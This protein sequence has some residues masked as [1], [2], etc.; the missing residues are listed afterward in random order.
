MPTAKKSVK[1]P[2]SPLSSKQRDYLVNRVH[3]IANEQYTL[4]REHFEKYDRAHPME[5]VERHYSAL[6][7]LL[8]GK[9]K[10]LPSDEIIKKLKLQNHNNSCGVRCPSLTEFID[11]PVEKLEALAEASMKK[12]NKIDDERHLIFQN[13]MK[14]KVQLL[15]ELYLVDITGAARIV[16]ALETFAHKKYI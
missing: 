16:K 7:A 15:D 5:Y 3:E 10:L 14:D 9:V 12:Y 8:A 13:I 2:T 11:A 6:H 1:K 4:V